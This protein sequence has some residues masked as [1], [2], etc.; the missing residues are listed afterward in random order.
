M[1]PSSICRLISDGGIL[2]LIRSN[3]VQDGPPRPQLAYDHSFREMTLSSSFS[4]TGLIHQV[5]KFR[6]C[7]GC[8]Q[9]ALVCRGR[10]HGAVD[11]LMQPWD[12]A[13]IIP[14]IEEAGGIATTLSAY[15]QGIVFGGNLLTSCDASLHHEMLELIHPNGVGVR[16]G[17]IIAQTES[18]DQDD[19]IG[20]IVA[21]GVGDK[22]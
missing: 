7:G 6:F 14:C 16:D 22:R 9:H 15:R 5:R 4:Q 21:T 17:K 1:L 19:A 11:T 12:S 18:T 20:H 3:R 8:L 10:I 2:E 13:A